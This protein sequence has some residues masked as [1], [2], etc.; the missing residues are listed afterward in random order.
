[1]T[2][3]FWPLAVLLIALQTGSHAC[4]RFMEEEAP[5]VAVVQTRLE[6]AL[7]QHESR[8]VWEERAKVRKE[9]ADKLWNFRSENNLTV[10]LVH[11]GRLEEALRRMETVERSYP[12]QIS[13]AYNL[14]TVYELKGDLPKARSWIKRGVELELLSGSKSHLNGT[15]W[16]HLRILDAKMDLKSDPRTWG[17]YAVSGLDFGQSRVPVAPQTFPSGNGGATLTL[18]RVQNSLQEQL[19]E[20]LEFV[21]APDPIMGDLLFDFANVLA[22]NGNTEDAQDIY[23]MALQFAPTRAALARSRFDYFAGTPNYLLIGCCC[24]L[25]LGAAGFYIIKRNRERHQEWKKIPIQTL[26]DLG[27]ERRTAFLDFSNQNET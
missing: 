27:P 11:L 5:S 26:D 1:M 9:E 17:N 15:E 4:L 18:A 23:Q 6:D 10:A 24:S 7:Q 22:V 12:N 8:S 21:K 14:G 20:R 3:R 19:H 13:T 16:L 25:V 2:P